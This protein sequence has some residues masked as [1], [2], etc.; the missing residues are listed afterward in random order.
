MLASGEAQQV[1]YGVN[2]HGIQMGDAPGQVPME[3]LQK[4]I[5]GLPKNLDKLQIE[6]ARSRLKA[7]DAMKSRVPLPKGPLPNATKN[8]RKMMRG[9]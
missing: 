2:V 8:T 7:L 1:L 3:K 9:H 6:E 5:E 4:H